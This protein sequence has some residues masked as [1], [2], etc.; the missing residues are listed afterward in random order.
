M[1][2]YA[3]AIRS[4]FAYMQMHQN[5]CLVNKEIENFVNKRLKPIMKIILFNAFTAY[6]MPCDSL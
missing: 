1:V 6:V 5:R 3:L 4:N 2:I